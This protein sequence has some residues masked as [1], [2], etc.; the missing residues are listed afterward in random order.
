[1]KTTNLLLLLSMFFILGCRKNKDEFAG[2]GSKIVPR[3]ILSSDKYNELL[4]EIAYE[5]DHAPD[6][7]AVDMFRNFVLTR[8]N[9]PKGV[10]IMYNPIPNQNKTLYTVSDINSLELKYRKEYPRKKKLTL[11]VFY[12]WADYSENTSSGKVMG[13]AYGSSSFAVFGK[14]TQDY[15]GGITQPSQKILEATVFEHEMGHLLGLVNNGSP[16]VSY[17]EANNHHCDNEDCLMY[18]AVETTDFVANLLGGSVPALDQHCIDD[19]RN[20]GGK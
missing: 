9:K 7:D 17:H 14:T 20:N 11:F 6:Q 5:G 12:A 10:S 4:I 18:Y 1:M 13:A 3:E 8:V 15:S 2:T 19:V 16:M